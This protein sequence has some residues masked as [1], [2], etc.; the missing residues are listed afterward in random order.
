[1]NEIKLDGILETALYC[2][3]LNAAEIFY[4]RILGLEKEQ[5]AGNRHVFFRCGQSMLLIFNPN[6]TIKEPSSP[7]MPVPPHGSTGEGH[8]CFKASA[9]ELDGIMEALDENDI[10][11]EADFRWPNGARSIY[12]RDPAGNS[13]E[14]AEPRLWNIED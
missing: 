14:F 4:G 2:E 6:E 12:I 13:V 11:V 9:E 1:M 5:R 10:F 7:D 3:T 8:V